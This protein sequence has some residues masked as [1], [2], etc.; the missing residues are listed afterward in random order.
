ML[1]ALAGVL[2]AGTACF[3]LLTGRDKKAASSA[4]PCAGLEGQAKEDC[5]RRHGR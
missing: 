2:G 4:E 1:V 3:G 5:E